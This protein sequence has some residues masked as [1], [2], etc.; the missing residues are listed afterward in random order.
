MLIL[1]APKD[2]W[3]AW[4][5]EGWRLPWIV[6]TDRSGWSVLLEREE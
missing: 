6:Q 3:L 4:L 1:Y 5:A 2:Q